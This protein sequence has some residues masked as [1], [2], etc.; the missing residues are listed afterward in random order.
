MNFLI[1]LYAYHLWG[2]VIWLWDILFKTRTNRLLRENSRR[3]LLDMYSPL[4]A[5]AAY[6]DRFRSKEFKLFSQNGEDGLLLYIFSQIGTTNRTLVEFGVESGRECNG[7][8]LL[9]NFGWN[10]LLMDGSSRNIENGRTWYRS[11]GLGNI[12]E[13]KLHNCF[14]TVDNINQVISD[15][16]IGD[17]I[18]LLSVDIDGNDYWVW[19]VIDVVKPRV[20]VVEYNSCFGAVRSL[21]VD[22][23]PAFTRFGKH[24]S[25]WYH[26]ASLTALTKLAKEKGFELV[27]TESKGCNAFFVRADLVQGELEIT[28]PET[29]FY[30]QPKRLKI[31]PQEEQFS[32]IAHLP[33]TEI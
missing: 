32:V 3:L 16:N 2:R 23:D 21:T 11:L 5:D 12:D 20:V 22:Y 29:A 28:N 8:N 27:G 10:G 9:I 18:D 19:Q 6:K 24:K 31:A 4:P 14:I 33:M 25:G 30:G 15:Q 7:A 17:E 26:G 13:I 1:R